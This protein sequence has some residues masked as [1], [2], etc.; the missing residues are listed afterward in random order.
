M[1]VRHAMWR[2]RAARALL[3]AYPQPWRTR[4]EP[5][6]LA[7]LDDDPPSLGGLASL[8]AGAADAHLRPRRGWRG[9]LS[10]TT[11][12]RLSIG[13][14][15]CCWI[16]L[17]L[18]GIG[19]QKDTEDP[20]FIA[21]GARHPLLAVA[22]GTVVAG[23]VLGGLAIA[24]GG[25]PLL[26]QG[27]RQALRGR[28]VRLGL[29]L[30]SPVG[31]LIAFAALTWLLM[32]IAP[33]RHGHFPVGFVLLFQAP[34]R[35]AGWL[36]AAVCALAPRIVMARTPIRS[37]ELRRASYAGAA[38]ALAMVVVTGGLVIYA[39]ALV[40]QAGGLAGMS[41]GPVGASTGVMLILYAATACLVSALGLTASKR[42]L[43]AAGA[44][45]RRQS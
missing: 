32:R 5:E 37:R 10:P 43:R 42:A 7:L 40:V 3:L 23:A 30:L 41:T 19:F 27:V 38:L 20:G 29:A 13:G 33:G 4:Y 24:V 21:A 15:F 14:L 25:L 39:C 17:C 6:V 12:M 9:A 44:H 26:W 16:V 28:D 34:W 31:A 11:R 36:C 22:H 18:N 35:L 1:S 8:I 2:K 45:S